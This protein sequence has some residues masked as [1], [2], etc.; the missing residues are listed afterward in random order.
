M[1]S[2]AEAHPDAGV[3]STRLLNPN[4]TLQPSCYHFPTIKNAIRGRFEKYAPAGDKPVSV[5]AVVGAVFM[6]PRQVIE[7]VGLLDEKYFI[8]FEDLDYCYRVKKS[9]FKVYYLP[10]VEIVHL[11][12][13]SGKKIK[14]KAGKWLVE[15]SKKYHGIFKHYL[16]NLIL[17]S[18][19]KWQKLKNLI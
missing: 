5:D 14:K 18:G 15:S 12:G 10:Q 8:Y 7:K 6:I 2:F 4:G 17:W 3:I 9:G 1:V 16:I 13:A 11:H 19:Q